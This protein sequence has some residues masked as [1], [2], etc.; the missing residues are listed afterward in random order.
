M[1]G[2][3]TR[4]IGQRRGTTDGV[5]AVEFAVV[6][7]VFLLFVFGMIEFGRA[8]WTWNTMRLA[9]EEGGR[10]AMVHNSC[11]ATNGSCASGCAAASSAQFAACVQTY[12]STQLYGLPFSVTTAMTITATPAAA[13]SS[14]PGTMTVTATYQF[15]FLVPKLLPFGP[16]TLT[17]TSVVPLV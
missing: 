13:S 12:A 3:A 4:S 10:Y 1:T 11:G 9:V 6:L 14:Y 15:D 7:P 8:Y 2:A 5:A 17:A 16:I